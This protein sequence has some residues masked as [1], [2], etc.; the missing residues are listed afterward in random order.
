MVDDEVLTEALKMIPAQRMGTPE[1]VAG[2]VSYLMSDA[3][4]YVTR[5]AISINGGMI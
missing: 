1:E 4:A 2:L 5:Q 3:A